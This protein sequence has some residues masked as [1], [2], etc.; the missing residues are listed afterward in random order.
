MT[1][2]T[3]I[4]RARAVMASAERALRRARGQGDAA[5]TTELEKA[6]AEAAAELA[7]LRQAHAGDAADP[8]ALAEGR[9]PLLLLPV[10]LETRFAWK[11]EAGPTFVRPPGVAVPLLLVRVF[12]DD[13]HLDAHDTELTPREE[14]LRRS[15]S[16]PSTPGGTGS[17]SCG[18]GST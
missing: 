4:A 9:W 12:P 5:G 18:R 11:G 2:L 10:R 7:A 6:R 3:D 15:S 13:I 1:A 14:E 16:S 8:F 17:T